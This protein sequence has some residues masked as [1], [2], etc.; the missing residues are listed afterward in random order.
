MINTIWLVTK[1]LGF[2]FLSTAIFE[3]PYSR[4]NAMTVTA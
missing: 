2:F 1:G 4:N 3:E